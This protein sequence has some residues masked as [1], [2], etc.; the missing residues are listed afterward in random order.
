MTNAVELEASWDVV[1]IGGG[2]AGVPAAIQAASAGAR[3][4]LVE[5][6]ARLGG[7]LVNGGVNRPGLFHAWGQ[8]VIAGIGWDVVTEAVRLTGAALPDFTTTGSPHWTRQVWVNPSVFA[9]ACDER[10]LASGAELLFHA[11]L[12]EATADDHGGWNIT[13]CTKDG[14][15]RV[16]TRVL[17]DATGD[18]DAVRI[19]GLPLRVPEASQPATLCFQISGYEVSALDFPRLNAAFAQAVATGELRPEDG[20]WRIDKPEIERLLRSAGNNANHIRATPAARS[21][22]GRSALEIEARRS[23][24]RLFGWL[25]RQPGLEG[26]RLDDVRPEVGIRETAT[27]VGQATVTLDD[28][29]S[30]RVWPDAVCNAFYPIDLHGLASTDWQAWPL[31]DGTVATI[32]RGALVPQGSCNLLAAGRCFSSD[33]LANSA[34]RV[35][36]ACMAMGQA[37][38]ALAAL[39]VVDGVDVADV[40]SERLLALLDR[41]GAIRPGRRRAPDTTQSK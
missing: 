15:Q 28:V 37:A 5:K 7:T 16:T 33:R 31:K 27:I 14:L 18:A 26:I 41:H 25:R 23:V 29:Q 2:P 10:V 4:L 17:V 21:A 11:M 19:A 32:P 39:A 3:T 12:A 20:C 30:G 34:L 1:V 35:M 40:P 22:L 24:A 36:G 13:L 9:A 6:T 8:Q 38:G